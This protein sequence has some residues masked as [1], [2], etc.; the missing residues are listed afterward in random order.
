MHLNESIGQWV[1]KNKCNSWKQVIIVIIINYYY[2][3]QIS[4]GKECYFRRF[5]YVASVRKDNKSPA[6]MQLTRQCQLLFTTDVT[7]IYSKFFFFCMTWLWNLDMI[8][9]IQNWLN[10]GMF[11]FFVCY[12]PLWKSMLQQI[13]YILCQE[14][15]ANLVFLVEKKFRL[16]SFILASCL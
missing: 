8:L 7:C 10:N 3:Y 16:S 9:A 1:K 12:C 4:E 11:F 5:Y 15:R 6:P 14:N 13:T 2:Y